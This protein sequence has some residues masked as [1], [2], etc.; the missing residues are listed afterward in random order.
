MNISPFC[1]FVKKK[2]IENLNEFEF[3]FLVTFHAAES[4]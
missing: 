1:I 3:K 2:T 4:F